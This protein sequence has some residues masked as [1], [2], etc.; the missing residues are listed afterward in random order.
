M[1]PATFIVTPVYK[2]FLVKLI[3]SLTFSKNQL[4]LP[5]QAHD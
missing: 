4:W 1:T 2:Y 3:V 5:S